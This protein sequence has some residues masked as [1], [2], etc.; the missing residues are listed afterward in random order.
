MS[1]IQG[2]VLRDS[3]NSIWLSANALAL[4]HGMLSFW[5]KDSSLKPLPLLEHVLLHDMHACGKKTSA[6]IYVTSG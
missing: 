6:G 3:L 2:I 4:M 1:E 5:K